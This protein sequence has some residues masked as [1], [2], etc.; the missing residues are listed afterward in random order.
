MRRGT[1][2]CLAL[3]LTGATDPAHAQ[4]GGKPMPAWTN[5]TINGHHQPTQRE[6][7]Q[8]SQHEPAGN[9]GAADDN[10]KAG[11]DIDDLYRELMQKSAP[12]PA[13]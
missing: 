6:I 3:T 7:E 8:Y 2:I 11:Q 5:H 9:S 1:I 4:A 12:T 10:P 13:K